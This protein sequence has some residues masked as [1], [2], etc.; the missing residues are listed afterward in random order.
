[1]KKAAPICAYLR[2][3]KNTAYI[4]IEDMS[5]RQ[6]VN[7]FGDTSF[8]TKTVIREGMFRLFCQP[9]L[10]NIALFIRLVDQRNKNDTKHVIECILSSFCYLQRTDEDEE[11]LTLRLTSQA[12]LAEK[13]FRQL[14]LLR[15]L[16]RLLF[17]EIAR[18]FWA[19]SGQRRILIGNTYVLNNNKDIPLQQS[20][21]FLS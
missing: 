16:S 14:Q 11:Y 12:L 6:S 8:V 5:F 7:L 9:G 4:S 1:M 13:G 2:G 15:S 21:V 17:R 3:E 19:R 20:L 18:K 10:R